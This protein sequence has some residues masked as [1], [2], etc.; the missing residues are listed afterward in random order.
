MGIDQ[1]KIARHFFFKKTNTQI[2]EYIRFKKKIYITES[3]L[4]FQPKQDNE[5]SQ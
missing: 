1:F 4:K 5:E 3:Y 2:F